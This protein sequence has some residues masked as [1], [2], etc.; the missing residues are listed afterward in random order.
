M[1]KELLF[2]HEHHSL[3]ALSI[4]EAVHEAYAEYPRVISGKLFNIDLGIV[5]LIQA[6]G[7]ESQDKA[8]KNFEHLTNT[9]LKRFMPTFIYR[10]N[11]SSDDAHMLVINEFAPDDSS[12]AVRSIGANNNIYTGSTKIL[13]EAE[14]Y[15]RQQGSVDDTGHGTDPGLASQAKRIESILL[16][17][18]L[19][20]RMSAF[21]VVV[22][23]TD[24]RLHPFQAE[25]KL[26]DL[27]QITRQAGKLE[28]YPIWGPDCFWGMV[29][30]VL[31]FHTTR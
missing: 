9:E 13:D 5:R 24:N 14:S 25:L 30:T 11:M 26:R 29:N 2:R 19:T 16:E 1:Q 6:S 27:A 10:L 15:F 3:H 17:Y 4:E 7:K 8:L 28:G 20:A 31:W 18:S 21:S 22:R 12:V 23:K